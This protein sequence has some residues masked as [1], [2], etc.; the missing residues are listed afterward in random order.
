LKPQ[1]SII[2][3]LDR[4]VSSKNRHSVIENRAIH[5]IAS[6]ANL[7]EQ[8]TNTYSEEDAQDLI[9]RLQRSILSNDEK[10]FTRKIAEHKH[11]DNSRMV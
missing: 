10:K 7:C 6:M 11:K 9:R 3:E 1:I 8:I 4:H 5:L 2:E